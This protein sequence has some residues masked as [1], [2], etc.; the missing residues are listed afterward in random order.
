MN[1]HLSAGDAQL[2]HQFEVSPQL[3]ATDFA[4][5]QPAI[6]AYGLQHLLRGLIDKFEPEMPHTQRQTS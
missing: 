4:G 6:M 5:E 1:A 3:L 2:I